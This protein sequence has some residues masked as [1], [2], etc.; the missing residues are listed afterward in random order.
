ME[1]FILYITNYFDTYFLFLGKITASNGS[2]MILGLLTF[3]MFILFITRLLYGKKR[4]M[5][6]L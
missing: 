5:F 6:R 4:R 3:T 1:K 2:K